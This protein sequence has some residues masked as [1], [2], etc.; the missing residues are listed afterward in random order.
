MLTLDLALS[1][2]AE[3]LA[4]DEAL[5][6]LAD[7]GASEDLLRFWE[8]ASFFVVVG[9]ANRVATE[10]NVRACERD[11]IPI[12]RRCTGGGTVL[13]GPGCLNYSLVLQMKSAQ[14][15]ETIHG[16]NQFVLS[17]NAEALSK[18]VEQTIRQQGQTDLTLGE[19]K[20]C[21]NAQRRKRGALLFH[22]SI[23]LDLDAN[24]IDRYLLHPSKEPEYRAKRGHTDFVG[25]LRLPAAAVKAALQNAWGA[26]R[27]FN[28]IPYAQVSELVR[29]K[30][31]SSGWNLRC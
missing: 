16:T 22:G 9:Y 11:G 12:L 21:G 18:V 19:A 24:R 1:T 26:S 20:I 17:R 3:N 5:L 13:Q 30:Y 7:H 4:L 28:E 25:N 8:P 2:P 23:L 14:E 29:D 10:V 15:L 31:G 6:D 27:A